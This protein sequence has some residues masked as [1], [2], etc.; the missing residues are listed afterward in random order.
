MSISQVYSNFSGCARPRPGLDLNTWPYCQEL[1]TPT[2][3]L[4]P[5]RFI[6]H[7]AL[8]FQKVSYPLS[9]AFVSQAIFILLHIVALGRVQR[10]RK[11]DRQVYGIADR[12]KMERS[13]YNMIPLCKKLMLT[14]PRICTY[15]HNYV[16]F[17]Q[18]IDSYKTTT[19]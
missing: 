2:R 7:T 10:G 17:T 16:Q 12:Q 5:A 6:F 8:Y 18:I 14:S 13:C 19:T 3:M 4:W 1:E 9:V 11:S 15:I